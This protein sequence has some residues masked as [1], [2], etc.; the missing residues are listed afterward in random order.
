MG[1]SSFE[2]V[3]VAHEPKHTVPLPRPA[4]CLIAV[5]FAACQHTRLG[6]GLILQQRK[7]LRP[8]EML[9]LMPGDMVRSED[10]GRTDVAEHI[11]VRLGTRT[12]TK[13]KRAQFTIIRK[14]ED[15]DLYAMLCH[16]KRTTQPT[17][18]LFPYTID[19]YRTLL[20]QVE[21]K[22]GLAIGWTPHS[23][24]VG[25]ASDSAV[26]GR[27][28]VETREGGRWLADSSLRIYIDVV[29]TAQIGLDLQSAGLVPALAFAQQHLLAYFPEGCFSSDHGGRWSRAG[30]RV[31]AK[32]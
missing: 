30:L 25:Y 29:S 8:S 21:A 13:A 12:G 7:G 24:R 19:M 5:H 31:Q 32:A 28:F 17:E 11:A 15:P 10:T 2:W 20:K 26:E 9:H 6:C 18:R 16:L 27:S 3:G 4:A 23:A 22:L 1:P 14:P